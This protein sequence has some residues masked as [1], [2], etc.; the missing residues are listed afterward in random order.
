MFYD[1][2]EDPTPGSDLL[3][4]SKLDFTLESLKHVD[5]YLNAIRG[6]TLDDREWF[7]TVLRTGAYVGEVVRRNSTSRLFHWVDYDTAVR[8]SDFAKTLGGPSPAVA[9]I[10][11]EHPES[12][13][14][15][16]GKVVKF[17]DNGPEDST[18]VFAAVVTGATA[19]LPPPAHEKD[20]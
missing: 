8:H 13:S 15:P 10:L 16:L 5:D 4:R 12:M 18:Y 17:L 2:P 3:D 14:F 11:W 20:G 19:P 6:R 1:H 9:A 7:V